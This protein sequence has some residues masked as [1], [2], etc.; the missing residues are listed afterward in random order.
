MAPYR[1][2]T[3]RSPENF[4]L[5]SFA[6]Q[7]ADRLGLEF[8]MCN[9]TDC[10]GSGGPWITPELSMQQL[11]WSEATVTG[12]A[13]IDI[14][15]PQPQ[16]LLGWYRDAYLL[17][18]PS[19]K[20]EQRSM[21]D[22]LKRMTSNAG[23]VDASILTDY[24][25]SGGVEIAADGSKQ[26]GFLQM[27]FDEPFEARSIFLHFEQVFTV[28]GMG[29]PNMPPPAMG[30]GGPPSL[31]A[32][33]DG[34]RFRKVCDLS[35]I[36]NMEGPTPP[37]L[38]TIPTV[39][40]KY[41]RIIFPQ[42]SLVTD[43]RLSGA[44][45]LNVWA[46]KTNSGGWA[47]PLD[48]A[49]MAFK[50]ELVPDGMAIDPASVQDISGFM[51]AE[52]RLRWQ[53]PPGR[54]TILR[55][56]H[57]STGMMVH[58]QPGWAVGLECD[59]FSREAM[60]FHFENFFGKLF[61][62]LSS[63]GIEGITGGLI[64]SYEAGLQN[65]TE[66]L[67]EEF[68]KRRGY[69]L[70]AYLPAMTGRIVGSSDE[71]DKFLWD[72]RRTEGDLGADY[73]YGRFA[74]LCREHGMK[75]YAETYGG[76][77]EEMQSG[78]RVDVPMGEFWL[79]TVEYGSTKTAASVSHT[80]GKSGAAAESFTA[81]S[82][83]SK[84]QEYPYSLKWQGDWMYTQGLN[85]IV[86]H[87]FMHQANPKV[88]PGVT[89]GGLGGMFASTNTW[90]EQA[91]AWQDYLA[92]C[93]YMLGQGLFVADLLYFMGEDV[94][95]TGR[96]LA[97]LEPSPPK[98]YDYDIINAEALLT[99]ASV[100]DGSIA[101]PD[102]M[103]YR[104][105]VLPDKDFTPSVLAKI[106]E[107][108]AQGMC[109]V[110]TGPAPLRSASLTDYP[111]ADSNARNIGA[112]LWGDLDGTRVRE[113]SYGKGR[114][115]QGLPLKDVLKKLTVRPDFEFTSG[116]GDA[117]VGYIHRRSGKTDIYFVANRRRQSEDLVCT[118]RVSGKRPEIW[119]PDT[120]KILPVSVYETADDNIRMP[121]HLDPAGSA[122]VVFR[123]PATENRVSRVEKDG[124]YLMG[125]EPLN[126][127]KAGRY[128]DV[129]G[130]FTISAWVK[131][132]VDVSLALG[133]GPSSRDPM[134][135]SINFM[136]YPPSGE[137]VYGKGHAACGMMA[138][139][140]GISVFERPGDN[141]ICVLAAEMPIE[142]WTHVALVYR[143][144]APSIYVNGRLASEGKPSESIV[145]PG[146]NEPFEI[147]E[148]FYMIGDMSKPELFEMAVDQRGLNA[149]VERGLP[150]VAQPPVV[151]IPGSENG[152]VLF[153]QNGVYSFKTHSGG[154]RR[155][156]V[157]G[158]DDP[159]YITGPWE[160]R[161]PENLGAPEKIT[162]GEPVSLHKHEDPGVKYFSGTATYTSAFD[163][164]TDATT[165]GRRLYLD[166]GRVE[167]TAQ[168]LVN[169]KNMGIA[170]KP[171][172]R[173]DITDAV[174]QGEN[175]L[176]VRVA[177]LWPNR[178][179]GDEQLSE[180]NTQA[181]DWYLK[182]EAKPGERITFATFRHYNKKSPLLESGLLGPVKIRPA[183]R[184]T[185]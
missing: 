4:A 71:T 10:T 33:D 91:G 156:E 93:Q 97:S 141:T 121:L 164:E 87:T 90:W 182:G 58:T 125:C 8:T 54:W 167:V 132:E 84:W 41:F 110:V 21:G 23:P 119:E 64:D 127:A 109:M 74:E 123:S 101:L 102:G 46:R 140:N 94:S 116:S 138:G 66:K 173:V 53:P 6:A 104:L 183:Y 143:D 86:F 34:V 181:G 144:S 35:V 165:D 77:F 108:V 83:F 26:S 95:E 40:A 128:P 20:G 45:R 70:A 133:E 151:E 44:C 98:G 31:E 146:I 38:Q 124:K 117:P 178:L 111:N 130:T 149:L 180:E 166:L 159:S 12:G 131:P 62:N 100:A 65:W 79:G 106:G 22:R 175:R 148:A 42:R 39:T 153:W 50:D 155:V 1:A 145:H 5:L 78:S 29:N 30:E 134:A 163:V 168:V 76:P 49:I 73:Y 99:R 115:F 169:G 67:P 126:E 185:P 48:P 172:Y 9:T 113:R 69:D 120:G 177:N 88:F 137:A 85:Q 171:P 18:F 19:L 52:G 14:I 81:T 103:R 157:S 92:R 160:V 28:E 51:N 57:T 63:L 122:F 136:F 174:H 24:D 68:E 37:V 16:T 147:P 59:K 161:F 17:A 89:M 184:K 107:M 129:K 7:E 112:G 82:A 55:I 11:V 96:S 139:R 162:L 142:G 114:V 56:G 15:M 36:Q 118:F 72:L 179:I 3:Y 43:V 27:E 47:V 152:E 61:S 154:Q 32:S 75:S 105:L 158:I 25:L 13:Q 60:D 170:W 2:R 150:D 80:Y 176:E 135:V